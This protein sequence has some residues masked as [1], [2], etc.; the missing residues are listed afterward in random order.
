MDAAKRSVV[1]TGTSTGIG[2]AC[3]D[4]LV[5]RGFHVWAT[6]RREQDAEE[7]TASHGDQVTP[8][9]LDLLDHDSVRAA[10]R[11][12]LEAGPLFGLVNNAGVAL[13]GPLEYLPVEQLR[14]QVDINLVG[15]LLVTQQLLP[16]LFASVERDHDARIVMIGSIGGRIAGPVL[17]AYHVSKHG[18]VGMADTLRAE[19]APYG[20]R[21]LLV[22]PGSIATPIWERGSAAGAEMEREMPSDATRYRRQIRQARD[23]AERQTTEGLPPA[24]A[25]E[26]IVE[27]LTSSRPKPRQVIGRDARIVAIMSRV[28]PYRLLYRL[29]AAR[30]R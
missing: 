23:N 24:R 30:G 12:V 14:R 17:G 20:V 29:T 10:A 21:V 18:L 26:I 3:V 11:T 5:R 22:E 7:I 8:L 9:I 1:V 6:V 16:A 25:A 15:Q 27:T 2:R 28:L 19:L 4:E 13:P